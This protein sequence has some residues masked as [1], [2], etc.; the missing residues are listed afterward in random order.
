LTGASTAS[1]SSVAAALVALAVL[2]TTASAA[3]S[4]SWPRFGYDT[5]RRNAA[6]AGGITAAN[7]KRLVRR[8]I[9]L[10]GT[11]DSSPI[12]VGG[13]VV[14]T[15]SYGRTIALDPVS[16]RIRWQFT[17][18]G[19][20]SRAGSAQITNSSPAADPDGKSVYAAAPDGIVRKLSLATGR[21]LWS[22]AITRD[23][24]HEKLGTALNVNG[25]FV[26]AT[27][28]GFIG[29]APPYQG[30][31][32]TI[33]RSTGRLVHV[34]NSLCS[35]RSGLIQPSSCPES[36]SAIWA[37]A[38][39][40]VDPVTHN[41][42]VA[43]GDGKWDGKTYWGDSVLVLSPDAGKLLASYTP[44]DYEVLEERDIDLGS[45][46]PALLPGGLAL[47]GGKD[48]QL[49]LFDLRQLGLGRTGNELQQLS[50]GNELFGAP[51]VWRN[52]VF[53]A[54]ASGTTAYRLRARRLERVWGNGTGGTS[55]VVAGD[56]L[57]VYNPVGGLNVYV[58]T[59]GRLLTTLPA[60]G[61]H[62]NS[63]IVVGGRVI[64]SEGSAN[65]HQTSG[66]LDIYR[67]P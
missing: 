6:P 26:V 9:R 39:A 15:T 42:V 46:A 64:L 7:V 32:A 18:P 3:S 62:W 22:V 59:T 63:P 20:S 1:R 52:L 21:V 50:S 2:A 37:R 66:V 48:A 14:V 28:G 19:Y 12:A 33:D 10:P 23:P 11:V 13:V 45:T 58:A 54:T 41:L 31:V 27:T 16:G 29:D 40:V 56:L 25:R 24:T 4:P 60:G 8:Q 67:L 61:G 65:D 49:R 55:P 35:D 53:V 30:H 44:P 51:A 47:Q 38:G 36:G 34:W 57:Y 5:A 43:T 17:P